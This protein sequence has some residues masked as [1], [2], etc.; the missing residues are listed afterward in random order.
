MS[1][2]VR[3]D[4]LRCPNCLRRFLVA[5]ADSRPRWPCPACEDEL[6]LMVRSLPGP[7]SRAAS[8]LG[9]QLLDQPGGLPS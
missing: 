4:L 8:A 5:E 3:L 2:S 9:A 1:R 6:Q 7:P